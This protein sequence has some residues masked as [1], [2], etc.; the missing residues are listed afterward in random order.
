MKRLLGEEVFVTHNRLGF[1][2]VWKAKY[3]GDFLAVKRVPAHCLNDQAI[4]SLKLEAEF[5]KKLSH[6]R[7]VSCFGIVESEG[8]YCMVMELCI[9][10]SLS[11]FMVVNPSAT[12]DWEKRTDF[13]IDIAAGMNYLHRLGVIHRDLK[14]G[15][16]VL[17]K[18]DRA[19][20]TDF[21]LSVVKSSTQTSMKM[22]ESGTPQYMAP[23]SFGLVPIFSTKT[24][25]YAF[26]IVLWELR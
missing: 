16:V 10:G 11:N 2:E 22:T 21:G 7:I 26:S 5:M 3:K 24:D 15:N 20:I 13:S 23:E 8:N 6:P 18:H 19:K 4:A 14:L 25:V 9:N 1:G 12:V 17:D